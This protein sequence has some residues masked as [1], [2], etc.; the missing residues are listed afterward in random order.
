MI[1]VKDKFPKLTPEEYFIWE[2]QQLL[3]HEYLSGRVY[4]MSE[5]TQNHGRIASN[6]IF[7]LKGHLRG[8]GCQV[9]NS[10]CRVNI[11]ETE[12]PIRIVRQFVEANRTPWQVEK[13]F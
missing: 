1:A 4:A 8:G 10:D 12:S 9:G 11:F 5:G 13:E 7:I 2:E 6:I 3:R